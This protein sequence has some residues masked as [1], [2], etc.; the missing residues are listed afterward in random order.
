MIILHLELS[1][2]TITDLIM[3]STDRMDLHPSGSVTEEKLRCFGLNGYDQIHE[4][5]EVQS[6]WNDLTFKT[7]KN[8]IFL[9]LFSKLYYT[10]TG[11]ISNRIN[12]VK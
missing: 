11:A 3:T 7:F 4:F 5:R 12:F 9:L 10:E 2:L 1:T 6:S 8:Y